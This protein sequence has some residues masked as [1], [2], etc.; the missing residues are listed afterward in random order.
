[1]VFVIV[2]LAPTIYKISDTLKFCSI[3]ILYLFIGFMT[4]L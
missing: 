4:S 2:G 3:Y 1:M